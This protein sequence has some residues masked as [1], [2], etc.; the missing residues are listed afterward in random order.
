MQ[1]V[2]FSDALDKAFTAAFGRNYGAAGNAPIAWGGDGC[3]EID[4]V[5]DILTVLKDVPE[6][7]PLYCL[8]YSDG[9]TFGWFFGSEQ[10]ILTQINAI[11]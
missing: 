2:K 7:T 9:A 6:G 3:N 1:N 4:M 8:S 11:N 10:D 5:D